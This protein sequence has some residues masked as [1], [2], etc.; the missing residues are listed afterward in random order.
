[1][2]AVSMAILSLVN[3]ELIKE[4]LVL[5]VSDVIEDE[6]GHTIISNYRIT[7]PDLVK[8]HYRYFFM[9]NLKLALKLPVA[10]SDRSLVGVIENGEV[11]AYINFNVLGECLSLEVR[12]YPLQVHDEELP[13]K[14]IEQYCRTISDIAKTILVVGNGM[15][16]LI[17]S[18]SQLNTQDVLNSYGFLI[19][20]NEK[21]NAAAMFNRI[22]RHS[23]SDQSDAA[24][25]Y[26]LNSKISSLE[27]TPNGITV[28]LEK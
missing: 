2:K 18:A 20:M 4:N 24:S 12:C 13:K 22:T 19:K 23:L 25:F 3:T 21:L 16:S 6:R 17:W 7:N 11:K 26:V 5:I 28:E 10:N 14:E 27:R 15:D 1:M 9:R 8:P